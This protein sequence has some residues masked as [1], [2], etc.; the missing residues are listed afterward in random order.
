MDSNTTYFQAAQQL[1]SLA[2]TPVGAVQKIAYFENIFPG[3]ATTVATLDAKSSYAARKF[4]NLNPGLAPTTQLSATQVAWYLFNQFYG[5]SYVNALQDI[6]VRCVV[7]CSKFGKYAFFDDQYSSLAAW[8]SI[9]PAAYHSMQ[10]L[11][12]KR[13]SA[14]LQ[15][16]VNYTL[17]KSID[18]SSGVERSGAFGGGFIS[19]PW[20]P[21]QRKSVSDFDLRH[22][23]NS[24]W[25][26]QLPFGRGRSLAGG[27]NPVLD[28]V[29][30]GWQVSGIFRWSSG[31]PV[32]VINGRFWPTNW[33]INGLATLKNEPPET[34]T[35]KSPTPNLFTN[36]AQAITAFKN[37]VAGES[38]SRNVL[39][40][41]GFFTID[42][43]VGKSWRMPIEGHR[44]QFRWETFNL[45]NT[46]RFD[47]NSLSLTIETAGTFGNYGAMLNSPRVMQFVLRYE[48]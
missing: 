7:S 26:A 5:P 16:D 14:G 45:T 8:R 35:T 29:I 21:G 31:F 23:I 37:T 27:A 12:R 40:G 43:G 30:G 18:W 28:A 38:G 32:G 25:I 39:R 33:Q 15:F 41:D 10:L 24:N 11:L 2:G 22:Q 19:N 13:M 17:G 20:I 1:I 47:V 48:F 4:S 6:D 44:L 3:L 9:A 42:L 36:P 34:G 46:A